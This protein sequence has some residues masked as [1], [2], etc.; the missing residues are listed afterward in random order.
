MEQAGLLRPSLQREELH[1]RGLCLSFC[2]FVTLYHRIYRRADILL[3]D[4]GD[5]HRKLA[6][7]SEI[8][9]HSP[10]R[11]PGLLKVKISCSYA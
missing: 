5:F 10:S 8:L 7:I 1:T 2:L 6:I 11:K 4:M 3:F 9:P